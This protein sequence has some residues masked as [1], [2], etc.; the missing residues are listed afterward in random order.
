MRGDGWQEGGRVRERDRTY[1]CC[2]LDRFLVILVEGSL[3]SLL[4]ID[5]QFRA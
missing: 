5:L 4:L 3:S 1:S 2:G